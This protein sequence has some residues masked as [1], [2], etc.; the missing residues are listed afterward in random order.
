MKIS[1]LSEI[2]AVCRLPNDAAIPAWAVQSR[3]FSISRTADALSIVCPFADVPEGTHCQPD[4]R[5]LKI[6][7][8]FALTEILEQI[9]EPLARRNII[10]F[11][12]STFDADYI[13]VQCGKLEDAVRTLTETGYAVQR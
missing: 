4:W 11:A 8:P 7:V 2:L 12:V 3:F 9:L 1:I 6:A 10:V 13:L 5:G